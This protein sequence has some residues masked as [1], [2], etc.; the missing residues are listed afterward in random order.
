[1]EQL[2]QHQNP[3]DQKLN[4]DLVHAARGGED[5]PNITADLNAAGQSQ[6][7]PPNGQGSPQSQPR[8]RYQTVN[9]LTLNPQPVSADRASSPYSPQRIYQEAFNDYQYHHEGVNAQTRKSSPQE[10][11]TA[12][13]HDHSNSNLVTNRMNFQAIYNPDT[14]TSSTSRNNATLNQAGYLKDSK[15]K[16]SSGRGLAPKYAS[17]RS[18]NNTSADNKPASNIVI[19]QNNYC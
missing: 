12:G 16:Q 14:F 8:G 2:I 17:K 9:Q 3:H 4:L 5:S 11:D 15:K 10:L 18:I 1:M 13:D 7:Q 19:E 6:A